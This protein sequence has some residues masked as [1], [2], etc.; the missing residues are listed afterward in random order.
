MDSENPSRSE[1]GDVERVV[2]ITKQFFVFGITISFILAHTLLL[3]LVL[4]LSLHFTHLLYI[5]CIIHTYRF[6][7]FKKE[8]N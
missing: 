2:R 4:L 8:G 3:I 1:G 7:S 6:F 5:A